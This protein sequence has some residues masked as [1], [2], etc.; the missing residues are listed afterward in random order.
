M[1]RALL[2]RSKVL[3]MDEVCRV[4]LIYVQVS[5]LLSVQATARLVYTGDASWRFSYD[6]ISVSTTQPM[7]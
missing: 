2:K 6:F 7:S 3:V 1:A 4:L 5:D